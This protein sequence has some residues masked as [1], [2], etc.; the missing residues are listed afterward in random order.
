[1]PI[2]TAKT[3]SDGRAVHTDCYFL[4]VSQEKSNSGHTD[5]HAKE[6]KRSWLAIAKELSQEQD[7]KKFGELA[8][9]L[10][11]ALDREEAERHRPIQNKPDA[12]D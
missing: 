6:E 10:N 2:E 7:P 3:D 9:E 8:E 5:G 12:S 1:M 11:N 4:E